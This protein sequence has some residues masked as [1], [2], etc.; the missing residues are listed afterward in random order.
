[1][2]TGIRPKWTEEQSQVVRSYEEL[3]KDG[4]FIA[5]GTAPKHVNNVSALPSCSVLWLRFVLQSKARDHRGQD[6]L[7]ANHSRVG[8]HGQGHNSRK[9]AV[10]D[11]PAGS[12]HNCHY[13][14]HSRV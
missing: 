10:R 12:Q 2:Q 14:A 11:F 6:M 8:A 7:T 3:S 9:M 5:N 13:R 4:P 1:M